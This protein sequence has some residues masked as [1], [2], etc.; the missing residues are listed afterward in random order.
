[1][2]T[3]TLDGIAGARVT[4]PSGSSDVGGRTEDTRGLNWHRWR[5]YGEIKTWF[6]DNDFHFDKGAGVKTYTNA[7]KAHFKGASFTYGGSNSGK[8]YWTRSPLAGVADHAR[9]VSSDGFLYLSRV[10]IE[11]LGVRPAFLL[12]LS[13]F[14]F[15]S[16]SIFSPTEAGSPDNPY[17]LYISP[18]A[19]QPVHPAQWLP[20]AS[21]NGDKLTLS[22]SN[23]PESD[24]P[25]VFHAYADAPDPA[26]LA[27]AFTLSDGTAVTGVEFKGTSIELTLSKTYAR[28]EAAPA[29]SYSGNIATDGIGFVDTGAVPTTLAAFAGVPV[30]NYT[31]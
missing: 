22:F 15:K 12:N 1:M 14:I 31:P 13:S 5:Y 29:V 2:I 17:F 27:K 18:S 3:P 4:L 20:A 7:R 24:H 30:S 25:N 8:S 11:F 28:N 23:P 9:N 19:P 16:A 6:G 10:T 21:I 26:G